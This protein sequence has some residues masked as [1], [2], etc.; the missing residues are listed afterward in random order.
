MFN[1]MCSLVPTCSAAPAVVLPSS[2]G[3][4]SP[5]T[6][7]VFVHVFRRHL[8]LPGVS[9]AQSF[10][11]YSFHRGSANW[12]FQL[13][14]PGELIQVFGDWSSEVY[15]SY[16]EFALPAKLRV[17]QVVSKALIQTC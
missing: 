5:I 9:W 7:S 1:R 17:A 3:S 6:K 15:K 11:G 8:S 13:G 10:R 16:L 14:L 2:E 12:A 4:L